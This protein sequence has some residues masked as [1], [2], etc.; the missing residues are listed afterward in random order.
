MRCGAEI[1]AGVRNVVVARRLN[2][3]I[4][5]R[6][7]RAVA[8]RQGILS[9]YVKVVIARNQIKFKAWRQIIGKNS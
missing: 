8:L 4:L 9:C 2:T 3:T 7:Q 5:F 6:Y 1:K